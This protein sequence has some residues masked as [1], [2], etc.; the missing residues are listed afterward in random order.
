MRENDSQSES[1]G[2]HG[3]ETSLLNMR[4]LYLCCL[5]AFFA[6]STVAAQKEI[7]SSAPLYVRT[8]SFGFLFAYSNDSSHM[9]IGE[10]QRRKILNI[11]ASYTRRLVLSRF[12]NWQY[13][14]EVLPVA[15]NSDPITTLT[16]TMPSYSDP[17]ETVS[18][19]Y[20]GPTIYACQ[21]SSGTVNIDGETATYVTT[22]SRRWVY[23]VGLSPVGFR[24]NFLP[25][26]SLQPLLVAHGGFMVSTQQIP[27]TYAGTFNF[28]FDI[29]TGFEWYRSDNRS[30][31]FEMRYH[32]ISN[33]DTATVNPGIDNGLFQVSYVFGR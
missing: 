12:V 11:G 25:R 19:T 26:R 9:L 20:V 15:L 33:A 27:I 7:A 5:S 31:R 6:A 13:D 24:W 4:L 29:G 21:A 18:T 14:G 22:C 28:T 32:H 17:S 1:I 10:A 8:N 16:L 23:G 2:P 30:L 3:K